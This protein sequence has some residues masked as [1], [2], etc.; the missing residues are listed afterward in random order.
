MPKKRT[1][2]ELL[3]GFLLPLSVLSLLFGF[4][5]WFLVPP[6]PAGNVHGVMTAKLGMGISGLVIAVISFFLPRHYSNK[7]KAARESSD[8]EMSNN[9]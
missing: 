8:K 3:A 7:A 4:S 6:D 1:K 9:V 2:T 5:G